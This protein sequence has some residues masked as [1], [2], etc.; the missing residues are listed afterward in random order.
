MLHISNECFVPFGVSMAFP[1]SSLHSSKLSGDLRRMLQSGLVDK[2]INEVR[3][4]MQRSGTG[5]LLSVCI[6]IEINKLIGNWYH[7]SRGWPYL[8]IPR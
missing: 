5:K 8:P 2:I 4:D 1:I 3:W 6:I 7:V